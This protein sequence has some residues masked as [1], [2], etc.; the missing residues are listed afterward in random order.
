MIYILVTFLKE[1]KLFYVVGEV[2]MEQTRDNCFFN[3]YL[4]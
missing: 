3:N 4:G 2:R 1:R